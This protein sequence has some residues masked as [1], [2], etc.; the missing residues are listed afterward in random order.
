M[1]QQIRQIGYFLGHSVL[2]LASPYLLKIPMSL[3]AIIGAAELGRNIPPILSHYLPSYE[4]YVR[5]YQPAFAL[6]SAL[7]ANQLLGPNSLYLAC[8]ILPEVN[9]C[10]GYTL[11]IIINLLSPGHTRCRRHPA[12]ESRTT[13]EIELEEKIIYE[14]SRLAK[15]ANISHFNVHVEENINPN[16]FAIFETNTITVLRGLLRK[17]KNFDKIM[18]FMAHEITHL[19]QTFFYHAT[20]RLN[21]GMSASIQSFISFYIVINSLSMLKENFQN[22]LLQTL[23]M[24]YALMQLAFA[25]LAFRL[26]MPKPS[27]SWITLKTFEYT[28]SMLCVTLL[29]SIDPMLPLAF[30]MG[31]NMPGFFQSFVTCLSLATFS[32]FFYLGF[33]RE[34]E[35][36]A[37]IGSIQLLNSDVLASSLEAMKNHNSDLSSSDKDF[38]WH[39]F[40]PFSFVK[41]K[42]AQWIENGAEQ[43]KTLPKV[44]LCLWDEHPPILERQKI[45]HQAYYDL[46]RKRNNSFDP[47]RNNFQQRHNG[48]GSKMDENGRRRSCRFEQKQPRYV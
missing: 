47:R 44:A 37:D 7:I 41:Y 28:S 20:Y 13:T 33:R 48:M 25:S 38:C 30:A 43:N 9:F 32:R 34:E 6:I 5:F 10:I 29:L 42:I 23:Q 14:C 17:V 45:I 19:N 16:A 1:W 27:L 18:G 21:Y 31:N 2:T 46:C 39:F 35:I 26:I 11:D 15:K 40:N 4:H 22:D 24:P 36:R 3:A 12:C 8:A